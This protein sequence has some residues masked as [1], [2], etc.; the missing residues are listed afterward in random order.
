MKILSW[1]INGLQ[2]RIEA[3]NRLAAELKPDV[4]CLQKVRSKGAS[5]FLKP[6]GYFGWMGSMEPG[7]F[8]GIST[9]INPDVE[10]DLE[11]Q[12]FVVPDWLA[13]TCC[14]NVLNFDKFILVNTYFPY[15][16]AAN[17]EFIKIRQRW[18][19]EIHEY[20][21]SLARRKPLVVCGDLNIV[22]TEKDAWDDVAIKNAGCFFD[23]EHWNFDSLCEA[24][25]LEDTYRF[26]HPDGTEYSY[27]FQNKPESRLLNQGFRIDYCLVSEE[28][29]PSLTKSEIL[30][31]VTETTNSP[32]L[33]ELDLP[34][35]L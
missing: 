35:Y 11:A 17:E 20:L 16:N 23:W 15:A 19:Y 26:L 22:A 25:G 5:P 28:L 12:N 29:L 13:D 6:D 31:D 8:G 4:I 1:N 34:E 21:E 10:F 32:L 2:A 24:V 30:T 27:F 9:F 7:L 18:D 3:V 33:I 14:L